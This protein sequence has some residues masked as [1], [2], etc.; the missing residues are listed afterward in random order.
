MMKTP[1]GPLWMS[2]REQKSRGASK[3]AGSPITLVSGVP[4]ETNRSGAAWATS[5]ESIAT[6]SAEA[7]DFLNKFM[8]GMVN[9]KYTVNLS[10][11]K[12]CVRN[13]P[14]QGLSFYY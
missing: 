6:R 8:L 7:A 10:R 4:I 13:I 12:G 11:F 1:L 14:L 5:R 9:P 3:R 2:F